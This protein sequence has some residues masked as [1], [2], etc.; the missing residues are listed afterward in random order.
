MTNGNLDVLQLTKAQD[1]VASFDLDQITIP[2]GHLGAHDN[3][4]RRRIDWLACLFGQINP[5]MQFLFA[6]D[7][8][9]AH[10]KS[11]GQ[12]RLVENGVRVIDSGCGQ[13]GCATDEGA[14]RQCEWRGQ[15][16]RCRNRQSEAFRPMIRLRQ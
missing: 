7:R 9:C 3:C 16:E 2:L 10:P 11:A 5:T 6:C 8:M 4:G 1:R 12:L 14:L 13:R 15:C